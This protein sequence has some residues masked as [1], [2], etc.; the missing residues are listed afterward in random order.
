[1]VAITREQAKAACRANG[2][3]NEEAN[4]IATQR[5]YTNA[6]IIALLIDVLDMF[7]ADEDHY[8]KIFGFK[9][10]PDKKQYRSGMERAMKA[11]HYNAR[12][13]NKSFFE[14][15][16]DEAT[17]IGFEDNADDIYQLIKVLIDHT[18]NHKDYVQVIGSLKRRKCNHHVFDKDIPN[19]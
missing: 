17:I 8:M 1:M 18:N 11:Y 19:L 12:E 2:C 15:M 13:F 10:L 16:K 6:S 4:E 9:Y 3:A 14:S 7:L 5:F